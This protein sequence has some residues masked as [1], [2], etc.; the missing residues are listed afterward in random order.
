MVSQVVSIFS[1]S[2]VFLIN[3]KNFFKCMEEN[4][5]RIWNDLRKFRGKRK[6]CG[7]GCC[8]QTETLFNVSI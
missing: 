3:N 8:V 5:L 1:L 2:Y 7:K 4:T 6:Y